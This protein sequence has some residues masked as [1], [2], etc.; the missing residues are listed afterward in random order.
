M[1]NIT[2]QQPVDAADLAGYRIC[3]GHAP[4]KYECNLT[5]GLTT[6]ADLFAL[7]SNR[8]VYI[9][10]SAYDES[11]NESVLSEAWRDHVGAYNLF[12][13]VILGGL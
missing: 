2:W 4:G 6:E 13:P 12:L 3:Y 9:A 5:V 7:Q 1:C 11:G 10:I 8:D